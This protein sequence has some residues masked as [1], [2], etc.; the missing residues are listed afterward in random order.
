MPKQKVEGRRLAQ[1]AA[2]RVGEGGR[3]I[4]GRLVAHT[5]D[6]VQRNQAGWEQAVHAA[7]AK[8]LDGQ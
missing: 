1:Y 2:M 8:S 5:P 4:P 3:Q 6:D 7:P